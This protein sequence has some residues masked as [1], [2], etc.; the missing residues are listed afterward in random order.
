MRSSPGWGRV[1]NGA[2]T[3]CRCDPGQGPWQV[4]GELEPCPVTDPVRWL[5]YD[6]LAQ[7]L[8][9]ERESARRLVIRKRWRR[10]KGND[11]KAI[12]AVPLDALPR[13]VT[14]PSTGEAP[15][16]ATGDD[17]GQDRPQE[18]AF[19]TAEAPAGEDPRTGDVTGADPGHVTGLAVLTRHIER[20]ERELE[21]AKGKAAERDALTGQVEAL[22]AVLDEVRRDRDRWHEAATARPRSWWRRLVG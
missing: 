16:H 8:G 3:L 18:A 9:I 15:G 14:A 7:A 19:V 12:V 17:T 4:T 2:L 1:V 13:S 5:G 21:D 11:G 6:E 20:L 22:K 10:S